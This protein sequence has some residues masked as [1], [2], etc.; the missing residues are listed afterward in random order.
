MSETK[1]RVDAVIFSINDVLVDVSR[2]YREVVRQTV[3]LYLE[4]AIGLP[5]T[6]E[7]LL[8]PD[9]VNLL[10]KAGGF[11]DYWDLSAAFVLYFTGLLPPVPVPTFPSKVHVPA[12]I[13]YLQM[14]GGVR[15]RI[16]IDQLREQKNI[17]QMAEQIA[18]AGGGLEGAYK[19][20]PNENHHLAVDVGDITRTNLVGRIFQELYLG[21]DLFEEIYDQPPV[22]VQTAGY[23]ENESLLIDR[24]ILTRISEKIPLALISNRPALEVNYTL[25]TQQIKDYFQAIVS[26]DDIQEAGGKPIPDPWPLLEAAQRIY[27]TPVH[28]AYIGATAGDMQAARAANKI[29]PFTAIACLAGAHNKES[30]RREFEKHKANIIL[31]HPN[32]LGNLILD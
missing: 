31:G 9:E 15:L 4:Q 12:I 11:A 13:A 14:A 5:G 21:A 1:L 3:Q 29:V 8:T 2:S 20:L 19:A 7:S 17:P 22:T 26:L 27:P 28:T 6:D 18:A 30:L 25:K 10:Q 16:T 23:I 32:N 24:D